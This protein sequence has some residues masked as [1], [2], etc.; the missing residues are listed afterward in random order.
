MCTMIFAATV[1]ASFSCSLS[2]IHKQFSWPLTGGFP[3]KPAQRMDSFFLLLWEI[4]MWK[5]AKLEQLKTGG[6][7]GRCLHTGSLFG[8]I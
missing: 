1:G 3:A 2:T 6:R 5:E 4:F 7:R 8:G